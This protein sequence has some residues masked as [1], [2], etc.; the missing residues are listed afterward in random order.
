MSYFGVYFV[1]ARYQSKDCARAT[2][3]GIAPNFGEDI[4]AQ[5]WRP[6]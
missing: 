5:R 3:K 2:V 1:R 6:G 4:P